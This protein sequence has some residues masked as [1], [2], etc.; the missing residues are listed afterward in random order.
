VAFYKDVLKLEPMARPNFDFA[1]AWFRTGPDQELHLICKNGSYTVPLERHTAY[2]IPD[3]SE[4][5]AHLDALGVEYE[6]PRIRPDGPLQLFLSDP[7]GH[8]IE[9]TQLDVT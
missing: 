6:G 7:D 9:L 4:A 8:V 1:G 2:R 3:M 5:K